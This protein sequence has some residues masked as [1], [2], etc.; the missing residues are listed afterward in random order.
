MRHRGRRRAWV[1]NDVDAE[2]AHE[3]AELITAAGGQAAVGIFDT[4]TSTR[5]RRRLATTVER[6]GKLDIL[7]N[8][9]GITRD[10]MFHNLD[11]EL[12][13]LVMDV[14]LKSGFH[15]TQAAM[16]TC[17]EVAQGRDRGDGTLAPIMRKIT[18]HLGSVV[19]FYLQPRGPVQLHRG[20]GRDH[21]DDQDPRARLGP[22]GDQRHRGRARLRRDPLD[23][24]QGAG[25]G[26]LGIPEASASRPWR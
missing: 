22:F 6:F 19:A 20:Q 1:V 25:F 14:N 10:K 5:P 7:V 11:E 3:T 12:F 15:M 13:D 8:N 17:V 21:L 24:R 18:F 16:P 4:S 2:P 9:A 26:T 23:R